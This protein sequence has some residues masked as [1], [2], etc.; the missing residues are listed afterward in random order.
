MVDL[1]DCLPNIFPLTQKHRVD[2]D[3]QSL[4][5]MVAFHVLELLPKLLKRF[6]LIYFELITVFTFVIYLVYPLSDNLLNMVHRAILFPLELW[7]MNIHHLF[8]LPVLLE[9]M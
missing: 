9:E 3:Q 6:T 8:V 2:K 7:Q 1:L 4:D 5:E